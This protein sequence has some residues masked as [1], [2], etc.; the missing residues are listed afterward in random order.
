MTLAEAARVLGGRTSGRDLRFSGVST[1]TR[2]LHAGDLF[3]ALR[4]ERFDGH[5]FLKAAAGANAAATMVDAKYHGP[6]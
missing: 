6:Y 1:D 4:G 3:V 5:D 2:T